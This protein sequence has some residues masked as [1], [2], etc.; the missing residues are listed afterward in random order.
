MNAVRITKIFSFE[1]A[2][3][4]KDYDGP[5]KNI[6]GHSYKLWVTVSGRVNRET[7]ILIDFG[8]LKNIIYDNIISAFDHRLLLH[9]EDEM[10][11]NNIGILTQNLMVLPFN[12]SSENLS[13][14]F[15]ELI[16][17][18]LPENVK[19]HHLKLYETETSFTEWYE[20]DNS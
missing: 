18:A 9:A 16:T 13:I 6:H 7:G 15:A 12:P 4:L 17:N 5:C 3:A 1:A 2:H 19:L 8:F 20:N 10:V 11:K 14:H